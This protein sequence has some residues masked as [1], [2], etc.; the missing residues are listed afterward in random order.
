MGLHLIIG[1]R[2]AILG[3]RSRYATCARSNDT[4]AREGGNMLNAGWKYNNE[5]PRRNILSEIFR[6]AEY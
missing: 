6:R 5:S 1:L 2:E 4:E 3:A